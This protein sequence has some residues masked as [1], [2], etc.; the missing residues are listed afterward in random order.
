MEGM[1]KLSFTMMKARQGFVYT[2][3]QK[4]FPYFCM[5]DSV[6]DGSPRGYDFSNTVEQFGIA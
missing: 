5:Y 1:T 2:I 6:I 3:A 4:L